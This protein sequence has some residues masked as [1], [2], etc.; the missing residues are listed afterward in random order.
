MSNT[1]RHQDTLPGKDWTAAKTGQP[2]EPRSPFF[3]HLPLEQPAIV[4]WQDPL[5]LFDK[6]WNSSD[7]PLKE[8]WD[9]RQMSIPD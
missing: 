2:I 8:D 7:D 1:A 4:V 6:V 3:G 9:S 5:W